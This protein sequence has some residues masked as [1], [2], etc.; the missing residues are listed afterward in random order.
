[1][2]RSAKVDLEFGGEV[3]TFK[4]GIGEHERF[5][6]KC[7]MGISQLVERL[8]PYVTATR[9]KA[10]F[11]QILNARMLGDLRPDHIG[12]AIFQGLVGG[13]MAPNEVGRLRRAWCD[14]RPITESAPI[15]YAIGI[16]AL[17]GTEDEDAAGEPKGEAAPRSPE[18]SSGSVKTA[19]SPSAARR[20][21]RRTKSAA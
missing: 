12:E 4:F 21:S 15:A 7:D 1:M 9:A 10:T 2:S 16:A 6:E 13:G 8:H 3:R 14:E 11:E 20:G 18:E 17:I 19:S 5:Q